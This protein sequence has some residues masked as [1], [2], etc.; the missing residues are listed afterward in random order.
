MIDITDT[1]KFLTPILLNATKYNGK[2][3]TCA[4]AFYNPLQL[5]EGWSKV[6]GIK[7]TYEQIGSAE[8]QGALTDE[9]HQQLKKSLGLINI[10]GYFGKTGRKDLDWTLEQMSE[11]PTSWEE[12]V[13]GNKGHWFGE[14]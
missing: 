6:T 2:N 5:I 7:V 10:W 14:E 9:M 8:K 11:M 1:G 3:F 12:F 13:S 4:T